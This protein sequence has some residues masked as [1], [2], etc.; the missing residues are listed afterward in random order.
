MKV[1]GLTGGIAAGKNFVATI[2]AQN[3]AAIFD[4]DAQ[5]HNLLSSD[6]EIISKIGSLFP[7]S[8]L[9]Q[10]DNYKI[11]RK[12]LGKIAFEDAKKLKI[13]EK[14]IHPEVR[15]KCHEFL[16]K[17][18]KDK[19]EIAVL[20]IPL[21]LQNKGYKYDKIIAVI[22]PKSVRKKRFLT[23]EKKINPI[24]FEKE[25]NDLEKKFEQI[26]SK[27]IS[28]SESRKHA[29]FVVKSAISKSFT[30]LFVQKIITQ[31]LA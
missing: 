27:Q 3:G 14:I 7:Q 29:D 8:L 5:V 31:I 1:V 4:A 2:F 15:K 12:I 23:R 25:K 18:Q 20:N 6:E 28:D 26:S 30:V 22:A 19:K 13:L 10:G 16:V 11:D 17:A 21:L 24:N 9:K